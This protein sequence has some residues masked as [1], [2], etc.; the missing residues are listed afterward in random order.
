MRTTNLKLKLIS[1][2]TLTLILVPWPYALSWRFITP[3]QAEA[4]TTTLTAKA[5]FNTGTFANT[6][7]N[8]KEGEIKLKSAGSWGARSWKTPKVTLTNQT[9][10]VSDGNYVYILAGFDRYFARYLPDEDRWQE[11]ASAPHGAYNGTSLAIMGN[12][13]YAIYGGYQKEFSRYSIINNSWEDLTDLPDL[14]L[15]GASIVSD[16]TYLYVTKGGWTQD[17][18]RYD[19]TTNTWLTTLAFP[20]GGLQQGSDMVYKDGFIYV[21]RGYYRN[22]YKYDIA[23]NTWSSLTDI[24]ADFY[25]MYGNHNLDI[26]GDYIYFTRDYSNTTTFYRYVI[27]TNSWESLA[28]LPQI[29]AYV[30]NIYNAADG[31][32]YVFRGGNTY[33]FWK[34]DINNNQFL[35][36]VDLPIA[37]GSGADLIYNNGYVYYHRGHNASSFYRYNLSS[38]T[39]ETLTS[40]PVNFNYD[41]KGELANGIIYFYQGNNTAAFYSYNIAGNSWTQLADA[42]ANAYYGG[43]LTYPGSGDYLYG[44]RGSMTRTFWRYSISGNSWSDAA[45]ADLP[46]N[47]EAG[48]GARLVSDGTDIYYT[49]GYGTSEILKYSI[50]GDTWTKVNNLPFAPYWGTDISYYN[51]KIYAQAG[52]FKGDLW[53]YSIVN[54]SWRYLLP[55]ATYGQTELGPWNSGSLVSDGAG[56][57]YSI[58]GMDVLRMQTFSVSNNNYQSTGTWTSA[59]LDL[60]YVDSW[61]SLTSSVATPGDSSLTFQT[62]SS[63]DQITWSSWETVTGGVISSTPN[64]YLQ[65][66]ANFAS[67]SDYSQTPILY[68]VSV[69]YTGDENPPSNPSSLTALSN[70]VGGVAITSG[71][72]YSY[73]YPYFSWSGAVD[74][75]TAVSGYYVYFGT[76]AVANPET[77]GSYQTDANYTVTTPMSN[78]TY[79]LIMQTKDNLGNI[80]AAETLFTYVYNGVSPPQTLTQTSTDDFALGTI[81]NV[82]TESGQIKLAS[83]SSFWQDQRLMNSPAGVYLGSEFAYVASSNKLY[84]LRGYN[85]TTFYEYDLTTNVWATKAVTPSG[86]YYGSDLAEGPS[87]Y[88]YALKGVNSNSFWRYDIANDTWSDADAADLPQATSYG[89]ALI[90]T[91]ERYIYGLRG[92]NDDAFYRYDALT[93]L[94]EQMA[95]V[96]FGASTNQINNLV[97]GGGDLAFDGNDTIY[98]IQGNNRTGFSAYSITSNQWL[99]LPN[100]PFL[101]SAGARIEYDSTSNAVYYF[102]GN[103]KT[104]FYK[105]SID[106]QTWSELTEVPGPISYGSTMKNVNGEL[107]VMRGGGANTLYKY[108]IAKASWQTPRVGLFGGW[109][110]GSDSRTFNYGADIIKGNSNYFYFTRGNFD[111]TFF[112]YNETTDEV[113]QMADAPASFYLGAELVYDSVNN[114]IYATSSNYNRKF[115]KY[116]IATDVWSEITTDPP[117]Y[118]PYVGSAMIF[119]GSQYIYWLR[120]NAN[121]F[122]RYNINGVAG[123]RWEPL[124]NAPSTMSYGA[125][126]VYRNGYIYAIRGG[127]G[128]Q[129][130]RYDVG[131]NT[132]NDAAVVDLPTGY[133]IYNDGF[134]VDGGGDY[135][136]ACRGWNQ[137]DCLR[138]SLTNNSW[139]VISD[140]YAP[141]ISAGGAAAS[142][143]TDKV[144][145]IPGSG[146]NNTFTNG[147]YTLVMQTD[148]SSFE[149][150]GSYVSPVHDLASVYRFANLSVTYTSA[151]NTT[152]TIS[153]RSSADNETWSSWS[154]TSEE[155]QVGTTYNY[156]VN[157]S[158][159]R[160][161]QLKFELSSSDGV[162][163]GVISDYTIS[164][165]QDITSPSNPTDAGFSAYTTATASASLTTD[166]WANSPNPYFTWSAAEAAYGASDG[167]GG[168]GVA[169]YYV[170]FGTDNEANASESGTLVTDPEYTASNLISGETYYL[171]IQTIDEAGNFSTENWQPFIYKFDSDVPS[172]PV[173]ISVNPPGYTST[174]SFAFT[175]K[176]ATD[177]ASLIGAYCYKYKTGEVNGI[178]SYSTETCLTTMDADGTATA[179][180][181]VA[182]KSGEDN[183]FYVRSKDNAGNYA[184]TYATQIYKYS[185]ESPSK[186]SNLRV[187]YPSLVYATDPT[188]ASNTVNEFAF[189]WDAPESYSGAQ[190]AIRYYYSINALPNANNV[191]ETGLSD[192]YLPTDSYATQKGDNV[193]YVV[194]KDEAGNIDYDQYAQ[195]TFNADT[196]APGIARNI[197]VSDVSIKETSS[198]RLALSW[199]APE[200]TGSGV[201]NYKVY[202]SEVEDASCTSGFAD[203]TYVASTTQTSYVDTGLTQSTKYYCVKACDSTNE[204]SAVSD[205]VSLYPDGRWRVAP[206]M[207]A[208]P[209]A[210]V[211]TK[212]ATISWSTNRTSNSFVKYGKSS[213]DYGEE[214]GSSTQ[215]T[216]HSVELTGLDPGTTYYYKA[217]WTDEDG[218]SGSSDELTFTTNP[219]PTVSTVTVNN[220]SIYGATVS[221][222]IANAIKAT[223]EYGID[224]NYGGGESISTSKN[225]T[226]YSITL[227]DLTEGTAYN[228]RIKAE[229]DEGNVYY[230]DNYTFET[231]PVPKITT[232]KIQQVVGMPKATLR[233][234]WTTNTSISS[235]VTYYPSR[236]PERAKDFIN[237]TL[238]TSHEAILKDLSDE[239][240]YTLLVSGKDLAGNE[241][242][243]PVQKVKTATD[244][245][246]PLIENFNIETTIVGVGDEARAKLVITWD[247]DEPATTQIEYAQG[248]SGTYSQTTQE[249]KTLTSNHTVTV[250]GLVPST[251]YHLR[252]ISKDKAKNISH[253]EDTVIITPKSTKGALELV[254]ENLSKSFGFLKGV[255][256]K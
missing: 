191:N 95:N 3:K 249:D 169:G 35:G 38:K 56:T 72:S 215:V 19:P 66:K 217:I 84:L 141:Y 65:I 240:E 228:F 31:Y 187:T 204:C 48:Y 189:A 137:K 124:A 151:A 73:A 238:K 82:S 40:S 118:D 233:L 197:D 219:A 51:G 216:A 8:S 12:Y 256:I 76:S 173:T 104:F 206:T 218:N 88:L 244:F 223:V 5:D 143:G 107:Y 138:Y 130:Y 245:R 239:T 148:N 49:S 45:V 175:M 78:D 229:D 18:W 55:M 230:S 87:G 147:L 177:S 24:P 237:L 1:L 22:F 203:F 212:T 152:L 63:S 116:D 53:E 97:G 160:Y 174:N 129:F 224:L 200:A 213:G 162:Y 154:E 21:P 188:P 251:I 109:F 231:L 119:D 172:N 123:A 168:S 34:Y 39:W 243:Y 199:D 186:P 179:S 50:T 30:G 190:S 222:T 100:A 69:N 68:S 86:A 176:G 201:A 246:A 91:G 57:F 4:A 7:A 26:N 105:Y 126:L 59:P 156:K 6:E 74:S 198:W 209:S 170:Y 89:A 79:Y 96:D 54:N 101:E 247:T 33:D 221:F 253:S 145:V 99:S 155:K 114:Q 164:Y 9:G 41:T 71:N 153:S 52:Y 150:S 205:T 208:S 139:E 140:V 227:S 17:F 10:I 196:S 158:A 93:D 132:W 117:P 241:A 193:F 211:K 113:V 25:P 47:A 29:T 195:I 146:G 178:V 192:T 14:V 121:T 236:Y 70:Q 235:I 67:S 226:T 16:G 83:K 234:V 142:N 27:S 165:Y 254:V 183:T 80:S 166:A 136:Y 171:R 242:V 182:Y 184:S 181:I 60:T 42:P 128:L 61:T 23:S 122:Y 255:K 159:N 161:L 115:Y 120:G 58:Y 85:T 248:T 92:N 32:L 214:T 252:A 2:V 110:R 149:E 131:A 13:I 194:A 167:T 90:S 220:V 144:Y 103:G 163:S 180:G 207:T 28:A 77:E 62:R 111:N 108:N 94:W 15:D 106:N 157:S 37:P 133:G 232:L 20:P 127:T 11:L 102:P 36:E 210:T 75:E 134:L 46:D 125:D 64:K 81:D 250:A 225:E 185:G 44:T 98:A 202:R 135:L 112:R 43:T